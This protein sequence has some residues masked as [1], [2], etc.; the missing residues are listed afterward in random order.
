MVS[1]VNVM[2]TN[3]IKL[4]II[5]L[6]VFS[7][8]LTAQEIWHEGFNSPEKGI[9]GGE[10]GNIQSDFTGISNWTLDFS[11]VSLF[12]SNDY[13]KTV[14]TSGG[15]FEVCDID[16]EVAWISSKIDIS[17]F[18]KV[19]IQ[20]IA[21]ETGSG[22]NGESKYLKAFYKID[23]DEKK[24]FEVKGEN[25]GNWGSVFSEQKGISGSSLQIVVYVANNYSADKVILDE[26]LVTAEVN[27]E[28]AEP[29]D[30]VLNEVLFNPFPDGGDFVEIVNNSNKTISLKN[31]FLASRDNELQLTQIYP[32]AEFDFPFTSG[33][34]LALTKDTNAVFPFY[35]IGCKTCFRQMERFPSFNNDEDV[36]VLLNENLEI[37]DE[38]HYTEDMHSPFF[39]DVE[40]VSLE[41][42]SLNE[43]ANAAGNWFSASA[44]AG[45]ATPGY[46]NSQAGNTN[47]AKPKITFEPDAFSPN[48]DGYNDEFI[49]QYQLNKS[50]FIANAWIF[51]SA[52]RFVLKL[53]KNK[54]LGT[55]GTLVWNGRDETGQRQPLGIYV[56]ALEIFS[57]RGEVYR[58]KEA[59]VLTDIL[60]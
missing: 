31:L 27:Y 14:S 29:G 5:F 11:S 21:S 53:A 6:S 7:N 46:E 32:V 57:A 41:R 52:G 22:T 59:V 45:Y 23:E 40:G 54:L 10:Q 58:Y 37:L 56:V 42:I 48:V 34:Y 3:I 55:K 15:R 50:G 19:K 33:G 9:W 8:Q 25:K 51:D 12:N 60:E 2:L 28:P 18:E 36:V 13:A 4:L 35:F 39:T 38:F 30:V 24:A 20:L 49:I 16:G 26:V 17:G 43:P 44:E 1:I 47:V